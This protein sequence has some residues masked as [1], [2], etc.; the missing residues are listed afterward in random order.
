MPVYARRTICSLEKK[1][2]KNISER[3]YRSPTRRMPDKK[4][5]IEYKV[6][7]FA[8]L[9]A[10]ITKPTMCLVELMPLVNLLTPLRYHF[11]Q[12]M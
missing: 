10:K 1:S 6:S 7:F 11:K 2:E 5:V 12:L 3:L 4:I 8:A 9:N